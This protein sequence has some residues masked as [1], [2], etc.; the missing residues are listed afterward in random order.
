MLAARGYSEVITYS[1]VD[2]SIQSK[3]MPAVT[4]VSLINPISS[5][6]SVMRLT[7]LAGLLTALRHNLNRQQERIRLFEAG[8]V[9]TSNRKTFNQDTMISAAI[10]GNRMTNNLHSNKEPVDFFDIKGDVESLLKF[11]GCFDEYSFIKDTNTY[12]HSGQS[13]RVLRNGDTV[14]WLGQIHPLIQKN[15]G[16]NQP[17]FVFEL[18]LDFILKGKIP[19]FSGLSKFPEIKRDLSFIVSDNIYAD[20]L[21]ETAYKKAGKI[22]IDTQILDVYQG[23][24]IEIHSKSVSL[25]LTFRDSSR[26]LEDSEVNDA[27][28]L[29]VEAVKKEHLGIL[30]G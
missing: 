28:S 30:R 6:M 5:D 29:I 22:L 10:T 26:T 12:L 20:D 4:P 1:F 11:Y 25:G 17:V 16:L 7:L 19:K 21:C 23:K 27:I 9:F 15:L 14:G 8:L 2:P 18:K 24:G 3:M 13:A